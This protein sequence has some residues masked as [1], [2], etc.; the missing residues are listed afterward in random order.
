VRFSDRLVG[1]DFKFL[2]Y[3]STTSNLYPNCFILKSETDFQNI[4]DNLYSAA[5]VNDY[6]GDKHELEKSFQ[7]LLS[8]I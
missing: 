2:D 4:F 6:T 1:G 3:Y 8:R 7:D 5:C